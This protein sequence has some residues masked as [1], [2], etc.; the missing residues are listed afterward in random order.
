[1]FNN[2][3]ESFNARFQKVFYTKKT[4]EENEQELDTIRENEEKKIEENKELTEEEKIVAINSLQKSYE[5]VQ[6]QLNSQRE[7]QKVND[8]SEDEKLEKTLDGQEME[9]SLIKEGNLEVQ[10]NDDSIDFDPEKILQTEERKDN[11]HSDEDREIKESFQLS[12]YDKKNI[13]YINEVTPEDKS[14]SDEKQSKQQQPAI[15]GLS[16]LA[17]TV[18]GAVITERKESLFNIDDENL[19]DQSE[20]L[21][22]TKKMTEAE[23]EESG[24]D[25]SQKLLSKQIPDVIQED[26]TQLIE[27]NGYP[28]LDDAQ[29]NNDEK[30]ENRQLVNSDKADLLAENPQLKKLYKTFSSSILNTYYGEEL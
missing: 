11:G 13:E 17:A 19:K 7:G 21:K 29:N 27:S 25:S 1:M 28:V 6:E 14:E 23:G 10:L 8:Y 5:V 15:S 9:G 22:V 18:G 2:V 26:N 16:G 20:V 30:S 3:K 12:E 24:S 4:A